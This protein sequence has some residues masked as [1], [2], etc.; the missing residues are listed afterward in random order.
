MSYAD[1]AAM[2][3]GMAERDLV[4]LTDDEGTGEIVEERIE[5]AVAEA[6]AL[7]DAYLA[8]GYVVPL[9]STPT[10]VKSLSVA[11]ARF[12]LY[13]RR[14]AAVPDVISKTYDG[15]VRT[16]EGIAKGTV[17]LGVTTEPTPSDAAD[18]ESSV[19]EADRLYTRDTLAG[20]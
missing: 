4:A 8:S 9:S 19:D 12:K 13:G 20:M 6:D 11:I 15:A 10:L 17:T 16:L 1:L 2:R 14:G 18:P 5:A 7:I 3:E